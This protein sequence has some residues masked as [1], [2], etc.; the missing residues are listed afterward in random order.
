MDAPIFTRIAESYVIGFVE[1]LRP[2]R[3]TFL[4]VKINC[5]LIA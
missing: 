1:P 2:I 3:I 5:G 4:K